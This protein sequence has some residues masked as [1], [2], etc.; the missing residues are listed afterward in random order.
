MHA[1]NISI[2]SKPIA[3]R[4]YRQ[5]YESVLEQISEMIKQ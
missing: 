5:Y 4:D 3:G 2:Y 1:N